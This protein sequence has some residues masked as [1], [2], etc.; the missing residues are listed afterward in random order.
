MDRSDIIYNLDEI[1]G[2]EARKDEPLSRHTTFK[3][4]G[5]ADT[6]V[7]VTSASKLSTIIKECKESDVDYLIIG[8]GS[9]LLASDDG[10][11]GVIIRLDGE[12]RKIARGGLAKNRHRWIAA[13]DEH[14]ARKL[15]AASTARDLR[16]KLVGPLRRAEVRHVQRRVGVKR[17]NE[18]DV[19]E[20]MAFGNHL[21][22]N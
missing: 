17:A 5:N 13:L 12:F 21:S 14:L 15:R 11:R 20:I 2:C 22:T 19:R 16:K 4:G 1:L 18:G 10:Y 3:I 7:K 8:N 9:N 6:Y